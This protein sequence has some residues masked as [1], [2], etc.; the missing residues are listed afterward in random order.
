MAC[1]SMP[2]YSP[3][4][5]THPW[6]GR[7]ARRRPERV[8]LVTEDPDGPEVRPDQPLSFA[9]RRF[10]PR[11]SDD[12]LHPR[13]PVLR[14]PIASE[15]AAMYLSRLILNPRSRAS[16]ANWRRPVR[17]AP[18]ASCAAFRMTCRPGKNASSGGWM[19]TRAWD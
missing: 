5:Q 8:R 9:E 13:R 12:D 17:N 3:C 15:E 16:S 7:D 11:P 14:Q 2:P 18:L 10:A 1:I 4:W 6:L 19:S